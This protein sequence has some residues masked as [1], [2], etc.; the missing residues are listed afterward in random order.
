MDVGPDDRF[1]FF[2][3]PV[4][5]LFSGTEHALFFHVLFLS[6]EL[7]KR[8]GSLIEMIPSRYQ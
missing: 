2:L 5:I 3:L 6:E 4:V 8:P 7:S 1:S